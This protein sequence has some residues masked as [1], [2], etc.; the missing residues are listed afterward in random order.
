MGNEYKYTY[1]AC[2]RKNRLWS[3]AAA[4]AG[5]R[6]QLQRRGAGTRFPF[7]KKATAWRQIPPRGLSAWQRRVHTYMLAAKRDEPLGVAVSSI[8][9]RLPRW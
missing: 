1:E 9:K 5:W 3:S 6:R 8:R 7:A 4:S 2:R